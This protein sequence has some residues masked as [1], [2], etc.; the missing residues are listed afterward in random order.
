[1]T[2]PTLALLATRDALAKALCEQY[3]DC[4][5]TWD[6]PVQCD[7]GFGYRDA[8]DLLAS[9]VVQ[10]PAEWAAGLADNEALMW[11]IENTATGDS[12]PLFGTIEP[13]RDVL[14]ALAALAKQEADR[15]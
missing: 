3:H 4:A 11:R 13:I 1:M 14:R 10:T 15:G 7:H 5:E 12:R 2:A 8:A 9:G 6:E